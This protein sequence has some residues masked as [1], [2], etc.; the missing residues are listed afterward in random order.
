MELSA[1][2]V[3]SSVF[4]TPKLVGTTKNKTEAVTSET[5]G[6]SYKSSGATKMDGQPV[7]SQIN[8]VVQRRKPTMVTVNTPEFE[9]KQIKSDE[10]AKI[11][12][13][14]RS[15]SSDLFDLEPEYNSSL[16]TRYLH[17]EP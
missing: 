1:K 10:T 16:S 9:A 5:F 2:S 17:S 15:D 3:K 8:N 14:N 13:R 11:S 6:S 7:K 4:E 12:H